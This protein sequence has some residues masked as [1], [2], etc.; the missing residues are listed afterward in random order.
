VGAIT[1]ASAILFGLLPALGSSKPDIQQDLQE[2]PTVF[3]GRIVPYH[4]RGLLVIAEV[5][6]AFVL[7]V[8]A[9]LLIGS[10]ERL[11]R[12]PTGFQT[13]HV[14]TTRLI[15]A[16]DRYKKPEQ[17]IAFYRESLAKIQALPD[18]HSAAFVQDLPFGEGPSTMFMLRTKEKPAGGGGH[19]MI[20]SP[21]YFS[22]LGLPLLAGREFT[23]SDRE[24]APK[25]AVVSKSLATDLWPGENPL[26]RQIAYSDGKSQWLEVIGVVDDARHF[27]LDHEAIPMATFYVPLW[28]SAVPTAF[29][30]VRTGSDPKGLSREVQQAIASVD[31]DEPL[32][33]FATMPQLIAARTAE[34]RSRALLLGIFAGLAV[35]LAMV[36][37]YGV[38]SY[39]VSERTREMGIRV[40]MGAGPA[41]VV[42]L[43]IRE[44][45]VLVVSGIVFGFGGALVLTRLLSSFL[46]DVKPTDAETYFVACLA[47][48]GVALLASYVPAQRAT[49][50]DPVVALRYE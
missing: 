43:V 8:G 50:V 30:A 27:G 40:A 11:M 34:P 38:V 9:G 42:R 7:L 36:G 48:A 37:L 4:T 45:F 12:V 32:D 20:A 17:Q 14:L 24:G 41:D 1:L 49:R 10:L 6:L 44:G 39:S 18:V 31:K 2:T 47:F 21:G 13:Q 15:L 35:L 28:Q 3:A 33:S 46:F 16:D 26:G 5:A 25:V 29:L 23:D 22:T 19:Y